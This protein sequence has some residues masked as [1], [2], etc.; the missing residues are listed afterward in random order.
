MHKTI[1]LALALLLLAT[2][3]PAKDLGKDIERGLGKM[4]ADELESTYGVVDDPLLAGWVNRMGQQLAAVSGR[5]DVKYSFKVLDADD[6]NAVSCPGGF[7]YVNR[8]TLGFVHSEDELAAVLGH[9]VGHVAGKHAMK[10]L[11]AQ[12]L[13]TLALIGFQ[14]VHAETLRTVGSLAGGLAMLKFSRDQENDADRRGLHNATAA[15]YDGKAMLTF[16]KQMETTEK[17]KPSSLEVYFLTHPPTPVR[18]AR[19]EKEPGTQDNEANA[20][21]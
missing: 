20:V 14:S 10:Q 1:G 21:A 15:G 5:T 18:V 13:G 12:L 19:V 6:I 9:E 11:N 16:F 7:V 3:V 2:A 8:G 4:V 17:E